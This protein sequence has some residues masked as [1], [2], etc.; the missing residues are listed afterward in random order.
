[1]TEK[2]TKNEKKKKKNREM[3]KKKKK[4]K[5]M[6]KNEE[7]NEMNRLATHLALSSRRRAPISKSDP[8]SPL[9]FNETGEGRGV[10][11]NFQ[12]F[13]IAPSVNSYAAEHRPYRL[14]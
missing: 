13:L 1:M 2:K 7:K 5:K 12:A 3:T 11:W 10:F 6:K 14:Q 4:T 8:P 9:G